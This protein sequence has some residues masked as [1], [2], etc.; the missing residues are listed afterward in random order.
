[1]RKFSHINKMLMSQINTTHNSG[2]ISKMIQN[3]GC[4]CF[5]GNSKAAGGKGPAQDGYDSLCQKLARCHKCVEIDHAGFI[6]NDWD[7]DIGK[8]RWSANA[9]G[10]IDCITGNAEQ[11]KQ[12]LCTCDA[13]Y[14]MEMGKIWDDATYD[15][16]LWNAKNNADFN[17]DFENVCVHNGNYPGIPD[18]CCGNYPE[19]YPFQLSDNRECCDDSGKIYDPDMFECCMDGKVVLHG[20]C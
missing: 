6:G 1:L 17:F 14:A 11:H 15:R 9:D 10:T 3:Y 5:P 20:T 12:D 8:Y 19:R 4:H 18:M 2:T 16:Q 13:F 7:A